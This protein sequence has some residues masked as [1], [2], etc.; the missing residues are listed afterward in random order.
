MCTALTEQALELPLGQVLEAAAAPVGTLVTG[1]QIWWEVE[2][3][4]Q[5]G[6][7]EGWPGWWQHS[8]IRL[9]R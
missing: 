3:G 1:L 6:G 2:L 7:G 8:C 4:E 5:E 9:E